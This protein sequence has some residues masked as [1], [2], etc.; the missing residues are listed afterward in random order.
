[1]SREREC[2]IGERQGQ[3]KETKRKRWR[4][5][6]KRTKRNRWRDEEKE[7]DRERERE[8]RERERERQRESQKTKTKKQKH[9]LTQ[10][11]GQEGRDNEKKDTCWLALLVLEHCKDG[12]LQIIDRKK[13]LWKVLQPAGPSVLEAGSFTY[14]PFALAE[15]SEPSPAGKAK[16]ESPGGLWGLLADL[17]KL[18]PPEWKDRWALTCRVYRRLIFD[19]IFRGGGGGSGALRDFPADIFGL[20]GTFWNQTEHRNGSNLGQWQWLNALL[21][22]RDVWV[23]FLSCKRWQAFLSQVGGCLNT[24]E[25]AKHLKIYFSVG[26]GFWLLCQVGGNAKFNR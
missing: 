5:E 25:N 17:P 24:P 26:E 12:T 2:D 6:E 16:K 9:A 4:D 22:A 14:N 1:M 21:Y 7:T 23:L 10:K 11:K 18:S 3:R 13:D 15:G 19:P 20:E 8:E